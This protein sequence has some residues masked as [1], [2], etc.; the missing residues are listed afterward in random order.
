M[1]RSWQLTLESVSQQADLC[2]VSMHEYLVPV[3]CITFFL[4]EEQCLAEL[5]VL[6]HCKLQVLKLPSM[7][8]LSFCVC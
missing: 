4:S 5:K 7:F 3:F 1:Q 8:R 2:R 6:A